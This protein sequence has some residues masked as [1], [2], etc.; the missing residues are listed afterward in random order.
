MD[1][2]GIIEGD[3]YPLQNPNYSKM[4][5]DLEIMYMFKLMEQF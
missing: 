3:L 2:G 1:C 5:L 4:L